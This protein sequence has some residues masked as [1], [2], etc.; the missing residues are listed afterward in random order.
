LLNEAAALS[1]LHP[2][3]RNWADVPEDERRLL[4][5]SMAVHA[6]M[7]ES[8][9]HHIGRLIA[10]LRTRGLADDTLFVVTSDN[11]PEPSDPLAQPAFAP[12]MAVHGYTRRLE[13]LGERRSFVYIG[14]EFAS[15]TATPGALF[16]FYASEGGLRVPLLVSGPDVAGGRH[17]PAFTF[18]TDIAPTLLEY[19]RVPE[20]DDG[21][22]A[23]LISGRSLAAVLAARA[24]AVYPPEVPV[25]V[26]VSGNAALFRGNY[27]VVRNRPPFGDDVWRLYDIVGDPGE[28]RDLAAERPELY[29]EL[30]RAYEAYANDVGVLE[31]PDGYDVQSQ[32]TRNAVEKQLEYYGWMA[33]LAAILVIT[34]STFIWRALRQRAA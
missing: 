12:W 23:P 1:P 4:A 32:V 14:P 10:H 22:G 28:T 5:R 30:V 18:V 34:A 16:K 19:A 17:V 15:A 11:G 3:L 13:D 21:G 8:M 31:L 2:S 24:D 6:G 26:E 25:G 27:K 20:R 9:D 7:L 33:G 29:R